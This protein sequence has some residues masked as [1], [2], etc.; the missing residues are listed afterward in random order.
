MRPLAKDTFTVT[1][2]ELALAMPTIVQPGP[3]ILIAILVAHDAI[4]APRVMHKL[5]GVPRIAAPDLVI[6]GNGTHK[7]AKMSRGATNSPATCFLHDCV[8]ST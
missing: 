8:M 6:E 3:G 5:A 2:C 1:V 7:N 4:T